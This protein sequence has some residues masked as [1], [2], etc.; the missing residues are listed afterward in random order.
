MTKSFVLFAVTPTYTFTSKGLYNAAHWLL[1]VYDSKLL[2]LRCRTHY[3]HWNSLCTRNNCMQRIIQMFDIQYCICMYYRLHPGGFLRLTFRSTNIYAI[4]VWNDVALSHAR[5][6][7]WQLL[8]CRSF[9]YFL[10]NIAQLPHLS[11]FSS[12]S[13]ISMMYNKQFQISPSCAAGLCGELCSWIHGWMQHDCCHSDQFVRRTDSSFH[14][15]DDISHL[16]FVS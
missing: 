2:T 16:N 3:S 12:F 6:F 7:G 15:T 9:H 4:W 13:S 10:M 1:N 14:D 11:L 5:A 8:A